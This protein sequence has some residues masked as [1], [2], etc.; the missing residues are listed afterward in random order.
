LFLAQFNWTAGARDA[1]YYCTTC[2]QEKTSLCLSC[3][4]SN[5]E[6]EYH[7][8]K[9]VE[10]ILVLDNWKKVLE[11]TD[12]IAGTRSWQLCDVNAKILW[13]RD[14]QEWIEHK[15]AMFWEEGIAAEEAEKLKLK[16]NH[17]DQQRMNA[18]STANSNRSVNDDD[19]MDET[20][21]ADEGNQVLLH[22][23][24]QMQRKLEVISAYHE[25]HPGSWNSQD[26]I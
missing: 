16:D 26:C 19:K 6:A 1:A 20:K 4:I 17:C 21:L 3:T 7:L 25:R 13:L 23:K 9:I 5:F 2:N 8:Q 18:G 11:D 12:K 14:R 10:N 24:L 15:I 22:G